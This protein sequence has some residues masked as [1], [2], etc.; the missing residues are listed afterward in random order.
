M[1]APMSKDF[2]TEDAKEALTGAIRSIEARSCAEVV[3]AV[4]AKSAA[5]LHADLISGI[6][7]GLGALAY[8]LWG[9]QAFSLFSIFLDPIL[10]GGLVG[11]LTSQLPYTRRWFTP[12]KIREGWVKR[13]ARAAF[14]EKGVRGTS[15][16]IG[17]LVYISL[18]ERHAAVIVDSGVDAAVDP[19]AWA[20]AVA[21]I[22]AAVDRGANGVEVAPL[23]EKLGDILEPCLPVSEDDVNELP[24]EVCG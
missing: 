18:L 15:Q 9:P 11:A 21:A 7:A 2:L 24:D 10:V 23:I 1:T 4:R 5:Y 17:L 20:G 19:E 13:A 22:D 3:I 8:T 12:T 16:R 14:Y 6:I